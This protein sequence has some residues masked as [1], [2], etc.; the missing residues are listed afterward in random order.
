MILPLGAP[1]LLYTVQCKSRHVLEQ[2]TFPQYLL[3]GSHPTVIHVLPF[4]TTHILTSTNIHSIND[5]ES[6]AELLLEKIDTEG[7]NSKDDGGR[8]VGGREKKERE[9]GGKEKQRCVENGRGEG[10]RREGGKEGGERE[11]T[12]REGGKGGGREG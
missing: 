5:N 11:G 9:R 8:Y 12:R 10:G 2:L 4:Y 1:S 7:V 6:C 3:P